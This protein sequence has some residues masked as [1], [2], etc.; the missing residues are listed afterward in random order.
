MICCELQ[1][2]PSLDQTRQKVN[3]KN[4]FGCLEYIFNEFEAECFAEISL[5]LSRMNNSTTSCNMLSKVSATR[6]FTKQITS[7]KKIFS[8]PL[9]QLQAYQP[10]MACGM[11]STAKLSILRDRCLSQWRDLIQN[12]QFYYP[13][14][15]S[16]LN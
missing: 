9:F 3:I 2:F 11:I 16:R 5:A 10:S 7:W 1:S 12:E 14:V 8:A 6:L 15:Q 4:V 13:I